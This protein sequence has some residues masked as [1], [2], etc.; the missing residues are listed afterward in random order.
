[1]LILAFLNVFSYLGLGRFYELTE[2]MSKM[3]ATVGPIVSKLDSILSRIDD[4]KRIKKQ[5][6]EAMANFI[7]NI[8]EDD[9]RKF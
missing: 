7:T 8:E 1:M 2:R 4:A 6:K 9:Q 3:E 5:K